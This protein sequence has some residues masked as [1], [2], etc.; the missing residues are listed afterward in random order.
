MSLQLFEE[1][2]GCDRNF[3]SE[4]FQVSY[5]ESLLLVVCGFAIAIC[6]PILSL[7]DYPTGTCYGEG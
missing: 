2:I 1:G 5:L 3:S 6:N 4:Y 7:P